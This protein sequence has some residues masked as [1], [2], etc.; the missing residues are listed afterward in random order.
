MGG[1]Q[2]SAPE[3]AGGRRPGDWA[4]TVHEFYDEVVFPHATRQQYEAAMSSASPPRGADVA[5]RG[6]DGAADDDAANATAS[7][8]PK[9]PL[10]LP[11][12]DI[13]DAGAVGRLARA[14][15]FVDGEVGVA[16]D[17]ILRANSEM[18]Q[19]VKMGLK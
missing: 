5:S 6:R 16:K 13:S 1:S 11:W 12:P 17:R 15:R 8:E 3:H 18:E 7:A 14:L 19:A 10:D 9:D 2:S 4:A